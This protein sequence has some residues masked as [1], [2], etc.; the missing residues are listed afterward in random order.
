MTEQTIRIQGMT[1]NHC[2]MSVRRAL[3]ALN[4]VEVEDVQIGNAVV[5]FDGS[6][7]KREE[8]DSAIENAGY[9]VTAYEP[10]E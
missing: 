8:I 6:D 3:A 9:N 4:G 10:H 5:R 1:C 2:V 7:E